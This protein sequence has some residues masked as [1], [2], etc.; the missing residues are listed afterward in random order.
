MDKRD[1]LEAAIHGEA[2]DRV[3]VALW[4]HWPGDDQRADDLAAAHIAFQREF[5]WDFV[6]VSPASSFCL[7][8]WGVQDRWEGN[9]EGTRTYTRRVVETP[10]DWLALKVLDPT[11]GALGRQ[12]R[13]LE[14]LHEAFKEEVPFIQT[15]FSPLA[16]AKNLAGDEIL[17]LHMRL[18]A[19]QLHHALQTIADTT[20][21]FI[22]EAK[23]RGIAGIYYAVQHANYGR[24]SEAEYQVFGRPYDLQVLAALDGLWFNVLHV[25]GPYGMFGLVGGYPVQVVNWHDRESPPS[26]VAG[27]K[28][29]KGAASGGVDRNVLHDENPDLALAQAREAFGQTGGRRWILST[30]CVMLVTTPVGN[31][32]KLRSLAETLRPA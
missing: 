6:K 3:P 19:G 31:I 29:I 12:L 8:D 9:L 5:D 10:E 17:T 14:I 28:L 15:V 22:Q 18:N 2:V 4:R 13:C 7:T 16:Q 32:R 26:L 1:R 20:V 24:L 23:K 25:H 11:Q 21:R 30:G 27:L